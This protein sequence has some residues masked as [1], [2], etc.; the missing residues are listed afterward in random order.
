MCS[1]I[2]KLAVDLRALGVR[3]GS[4]L[5]VHAALRSLGSVEGGAETVVLALLKALG[6]NGTLLFPALSYRTVTSERP[7]FDIRHTP[8]CVGALP[9]YF[10]Q[11]RGTWRS[12]HPT[13]SV[14]GVGHLAETL[15][16]DH[17]LDTTPCGPNSPFHKLPHHNGQILLL[18][19]GLRP[20]TSMHAIE[21]LTEPP[22]LFADVLSYV[23]TDAKGRIYTMPIRRHNFDGW[24]QRYDRVAQVLDSNALRTGK[25][26]AADCH[27]IEAQALWEAVH[28]KLQ[29]D[30]LFFVN[31]ESQ[32]NT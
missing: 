11:R 6:H 5:L 28:Q 1:S 17:D 13:H 30:A 23:I 25:V 8:S 14:C 27:L 4:V 24:I 3:E 20:N 22:Y 32:E 16:Q 19:C 31:R 18:G 26:L 21:E 7:Y 12:A 10:R 29:Q 15:L 9:E 2:S